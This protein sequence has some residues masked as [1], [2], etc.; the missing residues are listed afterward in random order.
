MTAETNRV[1]A[2]LKAREERVN[3]ELARKQE[4]VQAELE[5]EQKKVRQEV[6]DARAKSRAEVKAVQENLDVY[7][8]QG[9]PTG[10]HSQNFID[11]KIRESS[12]KFLSELA[13][14]LY[15]NL[16]VEKTVDFYHFCADSLTVFFDSFF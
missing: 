4:R 10:F 2:E 12:A 13:H 15:I 14:K 5:A 7:K 6:E 8:R 1:N 16:V 11:L 9:N 3:H